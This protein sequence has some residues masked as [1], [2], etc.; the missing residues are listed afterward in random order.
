MRTLIATLTLTLLAGP[1]AAQGWI[2]PLPN[3]LGSGVTKVRTAVR[4]TVTG[5]IAQ[6][7]VEEW[8]RNDG[9]MLG[10][11][12]YVYPL[13]GEAVFSNFSLF[14]GDQELRGETM[15][16][17]DARAI[18]E[19]IVRKKRDPA[20]IELVG[21]GMIRARVFPISPGDTR[22]I[23]LRYTQVMN[24]AGDALQFRYAAGSR[25]SERPVPLQD[26][27]PV[28][29]TTDSAPLSFLL[30]AEDGNVPAPRGTWKVTIRSTRSSGR[31]ETK[32]TASSPMP[33][34]SHAMS[35][36]WW[37]CPDRCPVKSWSK[38]RRPYGNS[39]VRS[40]NGIVSD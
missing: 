10:E 33:R 31:G 6:V 23:T 24:R 20:L 14:Q 15:N 38:A 25:R 9:R 30:T 5:R 11:G 34:S 8:F 26:G 40:T 17:D 3:V 19:E 12:D 4:V 1:L 13:P 36:S 32:R 21:H 37:M 2:E 7:E 16:A 39:S 35:P 18:Y 27:V 28:R 22:K 29:R